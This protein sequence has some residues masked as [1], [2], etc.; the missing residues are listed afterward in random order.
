MPPLR[1]STDRRRV[2]VGLLDDPH[3]AHA[4][5]RVSRRAAHSRL[6]GLALHSLQTLSLRAGDRRCG[7][8]NSPPA[9]RLAF[10]PGKGIFCPFRALFFPVRMHKSR[11]PFLGGEN[12]ICSFEMYG[13]LGY[14]F[15]FFYVVSTKGEGITNYFRQ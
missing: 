3:R 1:I 2:G 4:N 6:A 7:Y 12:W 5:F 15:E 13:M 8:S 14:D 9:L 11:R 10:A